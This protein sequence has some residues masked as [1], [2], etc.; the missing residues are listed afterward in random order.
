MKNNGQKQK[1]GRIRQILRRDV[2]L[3]RS[4]GNVQSE[5]QRKVIEVFY[6]VV[7]T[8]FLFMLSSV[9]LVTIIMLFIYA[10]ILI[11][12]CV[13]IIVAFILLNRP[14]R[15]CA[16]RLKFTSRLRRF[17]KKNGFTLTLN[18][19]FPKNLFHSSETEDFSVDTGKRIYYASFLTVRKPRAELNFLSKD[20]IRIVSRLGKNKIYTIYGVKPKIKDKDFVFPYTPQSRMRKTVRAVIVDPPVQSIYITNRDG[21]RVPSGTGDAAFDF[22]IFTGRGFINTVDRESREI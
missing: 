21:G 11:R 17:C 12:V 22:Y 16:K 1:N 15:I 3:Y 10:P 5:V 13:G 19:R 20:K 8:V 7:A 6:Q 2:P 4:Y 18:R 14:V 9:A